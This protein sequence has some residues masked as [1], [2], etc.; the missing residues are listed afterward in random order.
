M[1]DNPSHFCNAC[2]HIVWAAEVRLYGVKY[3]KLPYY[4][5]MNCKLLEPYQ[6]HEST[7]LG[8]TEGTLL[9]HQQVIDAA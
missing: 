7:Q 3:E 4:W 6:V 5:C 2:G 9:L 1:P 8:H